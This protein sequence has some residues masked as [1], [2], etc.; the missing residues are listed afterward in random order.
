MMSDDIVHVQ[1]T[2]ERCSPL[3]ENHI[4]KARAGIAW[5]SE[6]KCIDE[7]Y[8]IFGEFFIKKQYCI[9]IEGGKDEQI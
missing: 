7:G 9:L 2:S 1:V 3:L 4:Y 8:I 6:T 5:N